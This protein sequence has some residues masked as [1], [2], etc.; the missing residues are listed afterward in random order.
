MGLSNIGCFLKPERGYAGP[1][2]CKGWRTPL[3]DSFF[4]AYS[5]CANHL[6]KILF[7]FHS[8]FSFFYLPNIFSDSDFEK[9]AQLVSV[10]A[11][12]S[13]ENMAIK[14]LLEFVDNQKGVESEE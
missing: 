12:I 14:I 10:E 6:E 4:P 2:I 8:G 11:G 7:S 13:L 9:V 1:S 5:R 3:S